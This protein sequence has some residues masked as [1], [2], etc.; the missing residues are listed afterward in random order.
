MK[1]PRLRAVVLAAGLGTRLRPLTTEVPK[2]LLP[3]FGR[4]LIAWTL[5]RLAA[6][7]VDATAINL[8]HLAE[9]IPRALGDR[10]ADMSLVYSREESILGTLGALYPLRSFLEPAELVLL[11]NGDS[12]CRWPFEALIAHHL[13]ARDA[14]PGEPAVLATLLLSATADAGAFGGGV[15]VDERSGRV[16]TLLPARRP[17][18]SVLHASRRVFIGA[19]VFAPAAVLEAPRARTDIVRD[20]YEPRLES[21]ARIESVTVAAPWHDLGTP[22]RYLDAVL[23]WA[24]REDPAGDRDRVVLEAGAR[25]DAGVEARRS[26]V[27]GGA[28]VGHGSRLDRVVVGPGVEIAPETSIENVLVTPRSWGVVAGSRE[29]GPLVYTPLESQVV[30]AR[31]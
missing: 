5:E 28:R 25:L 1:A 6:A 18:T 21:G 29:E 13:A 22:G 31:S 19:H 12:L 16:L 27:L 4:T 15:A 3:V 17:A 24:A 14:S 23:D 20:F 2:A 30:G 26:L 9:S 7:G 10:Y 8:H 11:V